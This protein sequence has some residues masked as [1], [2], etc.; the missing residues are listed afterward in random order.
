MPTIVAWSIQASPGRFGV[1]VRGNILFCANLPGRD[2]NP[3]V[4]K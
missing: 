4:V 1:T 3:Q 2:L